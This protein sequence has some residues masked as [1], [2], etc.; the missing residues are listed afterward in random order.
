VLNS[1]A[2]L[3]HLNSAFGFDSQCFQYAKSLQNIVD[4]ILNWST[5]IESRILQGQSEAEAILEHFM[6]KEKLMEFLPML[7]KLVIAL[8]FMGKMMLKLSNF[9]RAKGTSV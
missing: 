6:T 4:E 8:Y 1:L 9:Q 3:S 7:N 5:F 2:F